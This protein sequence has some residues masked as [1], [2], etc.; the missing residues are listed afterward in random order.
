[1][2]WTIKEVEE[3]LKCIH[4]LNSSLKP[5]IN[6]PTCNLIKQIFFSEISKYFTNQQL[7][8][9]SFRRGSKVQTVLLVC[10]IQ[11]KIIAI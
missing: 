1:M 10:L 5:S 6:R 4:Y 9:M 3:L 7:N 11:K 8:G 2:E